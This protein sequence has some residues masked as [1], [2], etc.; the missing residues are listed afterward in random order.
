MIKKRNMKSKLIGKGKII[1]NEKDRDKRINLIRSSL[2]AGNNNKQM[3][4]ELK[5][6]TNQEINTDNKTP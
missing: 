6:L 3:L 4:E 1:L 5:Q 2:I